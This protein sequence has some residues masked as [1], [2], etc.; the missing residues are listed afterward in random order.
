[1]TSAP[2]RSKAE[3][4]PLRSTPGAASGVEIVGEIQPVLPSDAPRPSAPR[5]SST[6]SAPARLSA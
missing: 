3:R 5:S 2:R 6:T 4:S 1:M